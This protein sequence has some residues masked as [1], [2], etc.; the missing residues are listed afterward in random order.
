MASS[1]PTKVEEPRLVTSS[2][3]RGVGP[4]AIAINVRD[5]V[6][7]VGVRVLPSAARTEVRGVYG[8]RLKVAV[9]AP[10][11]AGKANARLVQVLAEWL[12]MRM[13]EV[14]VRSGHGGRDKVVAFSGTTENELRERLNGL[15]HNAEP[16]G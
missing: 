7:L 1:R 10:P 12:E 14:T 16:N 5:G 3:D 13:D 8:D 6:L 11:E 9:N 4:G 15:L 2:G